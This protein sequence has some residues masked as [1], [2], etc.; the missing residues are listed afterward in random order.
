MDPVEVSVDRGAR[1]WAAIDAALATGEI[2]EDGWFTRVQAVLVPAYLAGD[3]PR[4]QSGH[5]GDD[6]R[7]EEARRP[8]LAAVDRDGDFLDIGCASGYLMESVHRW[9]AEDGVQLEPYGLDISPALADL[10]RQRLPQWT[11]RIWVGNA[12]YWE[13]PRRFDYVRTGL[14]YVPPGRRG[15][16]VAHLLDR[17]VDRTLIVGVYNEILEDAAW[18][19]DVERAGFRIAGRREWFKPSDRRVVRRVFWIDKEQPA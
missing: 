13:P 19:R 11:D 18:E 14:D 16:L 12:L 17:V 8:V 2:D 15:D 6:A 1:E 10:A 9:A 3:N 7:W 5:S 4:A